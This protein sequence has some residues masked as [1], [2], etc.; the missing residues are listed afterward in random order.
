MSKNPFHIRE[1]LTAYIMPNEQRKASI[2]TFTT[3]RAK[4][5]VA[6]HEHYLQQAK[7]LE[8]IKSTF[9]SSLACT[10]TILISHKTG[11]V[12]Q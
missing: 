11:L 2:P 10:P 7:R 8:L 6:A 9:I 1:S 12:P 5:K 3:I 4:N